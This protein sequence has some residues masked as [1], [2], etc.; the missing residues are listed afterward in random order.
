MSILLPML[1]IV[2]SSASFGA[3]SDFGHGDDGRHAD[4]DPQRGQAG[5]HLVAIEGAKCGAKRGRN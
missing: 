3:L 2:F 4:D 5:P 1:A